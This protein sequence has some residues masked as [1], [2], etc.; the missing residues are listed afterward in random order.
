MLSFCLYALGFIPMYFLIHVA[1]AAG[2]EDE[3]MK[4]LEEPNYKVFFIVTWPIMVFLFLI[5]T[6]VKG[7]KITVSKK[8]D[9]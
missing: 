3:T 2:S 1:I 5:I 9:E 4:K 7:K 6:M 8:D